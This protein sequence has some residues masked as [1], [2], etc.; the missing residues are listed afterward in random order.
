[1]INEA[2]I[3]LKIKDIESPIL[4]FKKQ[5]YWSDSTDNQT[6]GKQWGELIKDLIALHNG[7]VGYSK[8]ERYLIIGVCESDY[9]LHSIDSINTKELKDLKPFKSTLNEK[10]NKYTDLTLH[11]KN[12]DFVLLENKKLLVINVS[13]PKFLIKL[14]KELQTKTNLILSETVLLRKGL[15]GDSIQ[16]ASDEEK[17]LLKKEIEISQ[18]PIMTKN[19]NKKRSISTT[20]QSF[21]DKNQNY[22]LNKNYPIIVWED[23][24]RFEWYKLQA[25]FGNPLDFL[26][27]N[28]NCTQYKAI[29]RLRE[30]YNIKSFDSFIVLTERVDFKKDQDS[31]HK[32]A[33]KTNLEKIFKTDKIYFIDEFGYNFLYKDLLSEYK[34]FNLSIYIDGLVEN[35]GEK[36]KSSLALLHEWYEADAEPLFVIKGHGGI[37]KT[38]LVKYFLDELAD[39]KQNHGILFISSREILDNLSKR[40]DLHHNKIKDIY[41]FYSAQVSTR[42]STTKQLNKDLFKLSLDNGSL[43]IALDGIDEVI[44]RLGAKFDISTFIKSIFSDYSL[45]LEKAKI[46]IT[47]RDSFWESSKTDIN[48]PEMNLQPFTTEQAIDFFNKSSECSPQYLR[49]ALELANKFTNSDSLKKTTY[50]PYILNLINYLLKKDPLYNSNTDFI[51][52]ILFE[53]LQNDFIIASICNREIKKLDN[54]SIDN[55][56]KI[57]TKIATLNEGYVNISDIKQLISSVTGIEHI[58]TQMIQVMKDHPVLV[59][60]SEK[61]Y[62]RYDFYDTYF[63]V[64]YIATFFKEKN[65]EILSKTVLNIISGYI[66]YEN[67][68]INY[69]HERIEYNE[70]LSIFFMEVIEYINEQIYSNSEYDLEVLRCA[71]SCIFI[72]ALSLAKKDNCYNDTESRTQLL[73]QFFEKDKSNILSGLCLVNIFGQNAE[74]LTF[75]F[76]GLK[77]HS[78][79][80]DNFDYFWDCRIDTETKFSS[81]IFKSLEPRKDVQPNIYKNTFDASCDISGIKHIISSYNSTI[82]KETSKTKDDIIKL[83]NLFYKQG[84]FYPQKQE[85]IRSKVFT[86]KLLEVLIRNKVIKTYKDPKKPTFDQ[87]IVSDEYSPVINYLEEGGGC[88]ELDK[89]LSFFERK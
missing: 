43:I 86:S 22:S 32:S 65:I 45:N 28:E 89:I 53:G 46:L 70:D 81:S 13:P 51:T 26:Y 75:D 42:D 88:L 19:N 15:K 60:Q 68:F 87:F 12:I 64:I 48:V 54:F 77:I 6:K 18:I 50:I 57:F 58:S 55:Q 72:L 56:V 7:Y 40:S 25:D 61:F 5:W 41:D 29:A 20:I 8:E 84:N 83:F 38:T 35:A 10:I 23:D 21:L 31:E 78:A 66:R 63:K 36:G 71:S 82:N 39:K 80:F 73:K 16:Q 30:N 67:S 2:L 69:L 49:K 62:F 24:I 17:S 34:K 44:A 79:Y 76:R 52:D 3:S 4:E 14:K 27:I 59:F 37:G 74:K 9:S 85:Y 47:C 33:R 1:M 11:I